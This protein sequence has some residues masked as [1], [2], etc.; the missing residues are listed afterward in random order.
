VHFRRL[1][2]A[3]LF[4][5]AANVSAQTPSQNVPHSQF[6][7]PA[8]TISKTVDEVNLAF[9]VTDG[10]GHFISNLGPADF[11]LLDDHRAPER[12]TFFQ[13]RSNLPLHLAIVLDASS[14]V[15]YRFKFEKDE[16]AA[17]LKKILRPGKDQ[18]TVI[19]FNDRVRTV[20]EPTDKTDRIRQVLKK[21]KPGGNTALNDAIIY[22][23]QRLGRLPEQQITRRA[24]V[25]IS[26]GV[27][28]VTRSSL[29][30]AEQAAA[31]SE[32]MIFSLT[33][34]LSD[35]DANAQGDAVLNELAAS[36]GGALLRAKDEGR[37]TSAFE[38]VQKA[39]RN[40]YVLA[41]NPPDFIA[42]GRYRPVELKALRRGL[43]TN[44]RRGYYARPAV[45]H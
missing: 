22:A 40:Q 9:T 4:I 21:I 13:Q 8:L 31:H 36:T 35:F 33:T 12:L 37:L 1:C 43:R 2:W 44:C 10:K 16:A 26:D 34:N 6:I 25:L 14:S 42:D 32:V 39:L 30:Q 20:V 15:E 38:S 45:A 17:F 11:K 28:T 3:A 41:Y 7:P 29:E 23:C 18:A 27:D 5:V 24:I 19:T